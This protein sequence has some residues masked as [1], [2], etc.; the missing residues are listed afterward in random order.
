MSSQFNLFDAAINGHLHIIEYLIEQIEGDINPSLSDGDTALHLA[1]GGG[2]LN[3]VSFYTNRLPNP[4]PGTLTN[5]KFRGTTP[6]HLAA[7]FGHLQVVQHICSL[8]EDKNPKNANDHTPLHVSA[9]N[10]HLEVVKFLVNHV[11][12]K[13]PINGVLYGRTT[14][15][16]Y[17]KERG[18]IEVVNFLEQL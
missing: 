4:N 18:H 1:A 13:H 10:G 8:L 5:D 11:E 6:L 17:A 2:H 14:P 7:Q 9:S 3:V 16:D 12:D 15:L